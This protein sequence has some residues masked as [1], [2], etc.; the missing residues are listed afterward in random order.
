MTQLFSF[1][2]GSFPF[3]CF[4]SFITVSGVIANAPH[5]M[6]FLS[7]AKLL[8]SI[9]SITWSTSLAFSF[10]VILSVLFRLYGLELSFFSWLL[11][12]WILDTSNYLSSHLFIHLAHDQPN[13]LV[14]LVFFPHYFKLFQTFCNFSSAI[15]QFFFWN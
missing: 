4:I 15:S 6:R 14:R 5:L 2:N 1:Q 10:N 12:S 13:L 11:I 8:V 7:S 9:A 3:L